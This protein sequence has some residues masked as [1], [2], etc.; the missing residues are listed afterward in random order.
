MAE[1][2]TPDTA[3]TVSKDGVYSE[4][5]NEMRRYREYQFSST[6]WYTTI[7]L[8]LLGVVFYA[9]YG[10]RASELNA[11][12]SQGN[13]KFTIAVIAFLLCFNSCHTILYTHD[14]YTSLRKFTDNT[15]E[16]EW[17]NY[18]PDLTIFQP[19]N[20]LVANQIILMVL[21]IVALFWPG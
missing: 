8:A 1:G 9:K 19:H 20:L 7:Y 4:L 2:S 21:V 3:N 5:Y 13:F 11:I 10:V 16:P 14:R 12:V 6:K 15:L 17:K 18:H